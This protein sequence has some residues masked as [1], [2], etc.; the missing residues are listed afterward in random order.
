MMIMTV[1]DYGDQ[2]H[3]YHILR[4]CDNYIVSWSLAMTA[5]MVMSTADNV[6]RI[7]I[8]VVRS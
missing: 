5:G 1:H 2:P 3:D 6:N 4:E 8:M 7:A